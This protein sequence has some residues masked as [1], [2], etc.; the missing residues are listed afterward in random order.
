MIGR[1]R[2]RQAWR[3]DASGASRCSRSA[4]MAKSTIMMPFFLTMPI[5]RMMP[6]SA[7]TDRSIVE[8]H[9]HQQRADA[10]RGQGGED[11]QRMDVALVEHAEDDVDRDQRGRESG[12]AGLQRGLERLGGALEGADDRSPACRIAAPR[13]SIASTASPSATPGARLKDRVTAGNCPW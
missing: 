7:M 4:W 11:R 1:K 13:F 3:I 10:G 6:M 9:Q 2:S 8:Q 5:S 12:T